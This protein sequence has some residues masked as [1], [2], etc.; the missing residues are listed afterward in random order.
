MPS[1]S[2]ESSG[3]DYLWRGVQVVGG[4][5]EV[6]A[7]AVIAGVGAAAAPVTGGTSLAGVI[8]GA[9]IG[10]HGIDQIQAGLRGVQS[11]A[12]QIGTAIAGPW[13]GIIADIG[14]GAGGLVKGAAA[15]AKS[16]GQFLRGMRQAG[17]LP[18]LL[19]EARKAGK[20]TSLLKSGG[21]TTDELA[22]LVRNGEVTLDE[23]RAAGHD[24]KTLGIKV[25]KAPQTDSGGAGAS[26]A[27]GVASEVGKKAPVGDGA[28]PALNVSTR[29]DLLGELATEGVKHSP[30]DVVAIARD[31]SGKIVFLEKGGPSAGLQHI[32]GHAA[33]FAARGITEAQIP[34]AVLKA[35]TQGKLVTQI[36]TGKN[37]RPVFEIEFEGQLQRISVGVSE[38]GFIVTA[39][40]A[41]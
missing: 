13:G 5:A 24:V 33:Q 30:D 14:P 1:E 4:V 37:A 35:A 28:K 34:D 39:H 12:S 36:G 9:A 10:A 23:L 8:G 32:N 17:N 19:N 7:G 40:P 29:E 18:A 38:N 31:T 21:L 16:L 22:E 3:W 11:V 25:S 20:L 27:D 6:T 26:A 41:S 15:G 2:T